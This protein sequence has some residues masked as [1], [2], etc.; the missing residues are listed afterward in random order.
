MLG[1]TTKVSFTVSEDGTGAER[2]ERPELKE[3]QPA[4][5]RAPPRT[6]TFIIGHVT[7]PTARADLFLSIRSFYWSQ[8]HRFHL[9]AAYNSTQSSGFSRQG[10]REVDV[11]TQCETLF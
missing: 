3:A 4:N 7:L 11:Q 8:T 1:A 9:S 10:Y 5:L 2:E 6:D